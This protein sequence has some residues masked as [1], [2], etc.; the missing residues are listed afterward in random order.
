ML[1]CLSYSDYSFRS[2]NQNAP[3]KIAY[4]HARNHVDR[5]ISAWCLDVFQLRMR[6]VALIR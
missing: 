5:L 2:K 1:L 4:A 3:I 6:T